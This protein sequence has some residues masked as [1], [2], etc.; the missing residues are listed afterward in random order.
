MFN[1]WSILLFDK[2]TYQYLNR[3]PRIRLHN[4]GLR[5]PNIVIQMYSATNDAPNMQD[6]SW[7]K[8]TRP[9]INDSTWE[10]M[11]KV[12][13]PWL[14]TYCNIYKHRDINI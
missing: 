6:V 9:T 10:A 8:A 1:I 12:K 13:L 2:K 4:S 7:R 3:P 5:I 14:I 11:K